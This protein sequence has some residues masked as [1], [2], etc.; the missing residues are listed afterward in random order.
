MEW[1]PTHFGTKTRPPKSMTN[2][3]ATA[4]AF[5][6][7]VGEGGGASEAGHQSSLETEVAGKIDIGNQCFPWISL[8]PDNLLCVW[9]STK[10]EDPEYKYSLYSLYT[11]TKGQVSPQT[12]PTHFITII[13]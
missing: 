1:F 4:E 3:S 7:K 6:E 10:S 9:T 13:V 12:N 8:S 5:L 2:P 11:A